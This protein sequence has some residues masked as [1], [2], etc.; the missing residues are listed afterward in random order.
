MEYFTVNEVVLREKLLNF[1]DINSLLKRSGNYIF[2]RF[3]SGA[4]DFA[5]I[6]MTD[7]IWVHI[8]MVI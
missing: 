7:G 3:A 2:L 1:D 4:S 6:T 8:T 5:E